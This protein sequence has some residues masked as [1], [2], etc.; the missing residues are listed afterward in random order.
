MSPED[1]IDTLGLLPHPEGGH[2][3][4]TWRHADGDARGAGTAIYHFLR[5]GESSHW[6][7]VDATEVWHFYAGAPI[8]LSTC[9]EGG[10]IEVHHLG[11]ELARGQRPQVII[12]PHVWQAARSL[13]AWTLVGCTVSPAFEFE[14][15]ELAPPDWSPA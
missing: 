2:Y 8:E 3:R 11:P 10:A 4:E 13:G 12:A 6:H 1:I 5:A 7:R 15:F 14:H 9:E